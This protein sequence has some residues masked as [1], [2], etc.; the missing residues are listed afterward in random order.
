MKANQ[1]EVNQL[2]EE[3]K[4][5]REGQLQAMEEKQ[6]EL[7]EKVVMKSSTNYVSK[8]DVKKNVSEEIEIRL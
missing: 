5:V 2:R 6:R 4:T 3:I 1:E 8:E 7:E